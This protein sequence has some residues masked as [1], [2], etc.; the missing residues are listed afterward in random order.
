MNDQN[1]EAWSGDGDRPDVIVEIRCG[2]K[3]ERGVGSAAIALVYPKKSAHLPVVISN[4]FTADGMFR[5]WIAMGQLLADTMPMGYR[6]A[7]VRSVVANSHLP[8]QQEQRTH[9]LR[10]PTAQ[11]VLD[12]AGELFGPVQKAALA[13]A[14][15]ERL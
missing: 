12:L 15:R 4:G 13:Q 7:W 9:Q 11:A 5:A 10:V 14:V 6:Q 2:A 1:L 3:V 8:D